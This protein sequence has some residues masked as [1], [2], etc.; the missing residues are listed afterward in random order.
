MGIIKN[1]VT[2]IAGGIAV[3]SADAA[4]K[5]VSAADLG[6]TPDYCAKLN[7]MTPAQAND[8]LRHN[9]VPYQDCEPEYYENDE[10]K[11]QRVFKLRIG[12]GYAKSGKHGVTTVVI[13]GEK[14]FQLFEGREDFRGVVGGDVSIGVTE[15]TSTILTPSG[16][17]GYD[18]RFQETQKDYLH[19]RAK[20]GLAKDIGPVTV[21]GGVG[22]GYMNRSSDANSATVDSNGKVV[23]PGPSVEYKAEGL[24]GE[25]WG[26]LDLNVTDDVSVGATVS[27]SEILEGRDDFK[28]STTEVMGTVNIKLD[29][30]FGGR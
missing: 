16:V 4:K 19:A 14:Q 21:K 2:V 30:L 6:K 11:M 20:V 5:S 1:A 3:L 23:V 12:A 18:F 27:H 9:P 26:G 7:S 13:G 24:S 25:L 10:G 15:D 17:P 8:E 22:L 29:S 28:N